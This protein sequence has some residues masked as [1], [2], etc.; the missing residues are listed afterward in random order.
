MNIY[1]FHVFTFEGKKNAAPERD[2]E[3]NDGD[4]SGE[5]NQT[6]IEMCKL[7]LI[8]SFMYTD[9]KVGGFFPVLSI[10]RSIM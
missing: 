7:I 8:H 3:H 5:K 6:A 4:K 10:R 1:I 2:R 9:A